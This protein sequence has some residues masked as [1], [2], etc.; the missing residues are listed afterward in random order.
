M[1]AAGFT[2]IEILVVVA[3]LAILAAVV[4]PQFGT[5][6]DDARETALRGDLMGMR[7]QLQLYRIHHAGNYPTTLNQLTQKTD[8]NGDEGG[9]FGPYMQALPVNPFTETNDIQTG[10]KG[11][12]SQA[13]YY[14]A[15]TGEFYPN[16]A[17][18]LDW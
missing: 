8:V 7:K 14:N 5:A 10:A 17:D 3:L 1:K 18:H 6:A 9:S 12:G 11:N 16:D 4:I 13:W 2:L 15:T